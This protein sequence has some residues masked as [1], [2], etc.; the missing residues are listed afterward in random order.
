M[1]LVA[2][3]AFVALFPH[4]ATAGWAGWL[5]CV[6]V[7]V[8]ML[9]EMR[10]WDILPRVGVSRGKAETG[11][12]Q[13]KMP[14]IEPPEIA[15]PMPSPSIE[16]GGTMTNGHIEKDADG[17]NG[18]ANG[19]PTP[20]A[21]NGNGILINGNGTGGHKPESPKKVEF[22]D[23]TVFGAKGGGV[24]AMPIPVVAVTDVD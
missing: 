1:A 15:V 4:L 20:P 10:G 11:P 18:H 23:V 17:A 3:L 12:E 22:G 2:V 14:E 19:H 13:G 21:E 16:D 24:Y 7:G 5:V 6:A 9:G 8:G